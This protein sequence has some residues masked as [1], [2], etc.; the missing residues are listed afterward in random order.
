MKKHEQ[1]YILGGGPA[2]LSVGHFA[3]EKKIPFKIIEANS[4]TGGNA[5]TLHRVIQGQTFYYDTGAHR[6]HDEIPEATALVKDLL[7][8]DL[9]ETTSSSQIYKDGKLINFPLQPIELAQ[10]FGLSKFMKASWNVF[11][12]RLTN[13]KTTFQNF[14]EFAIYKY[15][16]VISEQFLLEYSKKLWGREANELSTDIAGIRLNGLTLRRFITEGI[17][18]IKKKERTFNSAH[19]YPR[20]GYGMIADRLA[21]SCGE[22]NILKNYQ[23]T[24]I[25]ANGKKIESIEVNGRGKLPVKQVISTLPLPVLAQLMEPVLPSDI[26]EVAEQLHFRNIRLVIVFLDVDQVTENATIYFPDGEF[27]FSRIV[28]PKHRSAEMSPKGRTSLV[29]EIPCNEEDEAWQMEERDLIKRTTAQLSRL[30]FVNIGAMIGASTHRIPR[31]YPIL[32]VGYQERLETLWNYMDIFENL[33]MLGR[34]AQFKYSY[35]HHIIAQSKDFTQR[36]FA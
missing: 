19:L 27:P 23:V 33:D 20:L 5:R 15:G 3:K 32:E 8:E 31:A 2:G 35:L 21:E 25:H 12:E 13:K 30:G 29:I 17:L 6:F 7:K 34:N 36:L 4:E 10:H 26:Q 9:L 28:E 24:A 22:A 18:G 16:K 11:N 1:L 14:E